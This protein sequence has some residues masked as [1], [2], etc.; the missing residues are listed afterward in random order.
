[1]SFKKYDVPGKARFVKNKLLWAAKKTG[2]LA[3]EAIRFAACKYLERVQG[4]S[5]DVK[6]KQEPTPV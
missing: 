6:D 5:K 2:V 3:A 1:M 4:E